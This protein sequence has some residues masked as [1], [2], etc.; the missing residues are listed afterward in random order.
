[1]FE[2]GSVLQHTT[3]VEKNDGLFLEEGGSIKRINQKKVAK[4][5]H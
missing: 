5:N 1:M 2:K 4:S 3:L